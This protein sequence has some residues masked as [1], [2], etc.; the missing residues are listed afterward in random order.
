[1][2]GSLSKNHRKVFVAKNIRPCFLGFS[3]PPYEAK[4]IQNGIDLGALIREYFPACKIILF[5]IHS[6]PMLIHNAINKINPEGFILKNHINA[7]SLQTAY[8]SII[9]GQKFY[10][11]TIS[12][13]HYDNTLKKLNLDALDCQI[14]MLISK[15]IKT[16][17]MPE[18]LDL[19]FSAIE[20]RKASIKNKL[21]KDTGSNKEIIEE[22]EK[23]GL[24]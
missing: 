4:N 19:S 23:L 10:S 8:L 11:A 22:A 6:E 20:K 9:Q 24:I 5:T 18:H 12:K 21:L 13:I 17:D 7:L 16:K 14:L 1:M 2:R 3:L 15:K